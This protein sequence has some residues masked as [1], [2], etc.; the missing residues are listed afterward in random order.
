MTDVHSHI[1]FNIDDGSYSIEESIELLKK[2]QN[3]GFH[4]V[5]LTPHYIKGSNYSANN[6]IKRKQFNLLKETIKEHNL[7][8][9]IHLGNEIFISND[10]LNLLET[11]EISSLNNTKYL[12]I[13]LPFHNQILNLEDIIYEIKLKGYLPVIAHPE[14]YTYF[15]ENYKLV[16]NLKELDVMFQCNYV[17]ILGYYGKSAEKLVK[18]M[19]K[20]KYV[21]YLGTDIHHLDRTFVVDNFDKIKKQIKK[22]AGENY[23]N[24]IIENCNSLVHNEE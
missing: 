17:S 5:I 11:D 3:I 24:E 13:E 9:N 12:L 8:I 1:L 23:F 10:I 4:D 19:F 16:D 18:Y 20:N 7:K 14:R 22:V 21:D 15:Q 2:L 6:Q